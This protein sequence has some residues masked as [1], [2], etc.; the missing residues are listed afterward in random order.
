M[1]VAASLPLPSRSF[2]LRQRARRVPRMLWLALAVLASWSLEIAVYSSFAPYGAVLRQE[3][4]T[5]P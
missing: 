4:H 1:S 2:R 3:V 5:A